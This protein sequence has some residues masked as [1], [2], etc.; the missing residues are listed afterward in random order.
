MS[1]LVALFLLASIGIAA[2]CQESKKSWHFKG[3]SGEVEIDVI[4]VPGAKGT[5]VSS[6]HI[7]SPSGGVR[8]VQEESSFIDSV[9]AQL[10][11]EGVDPNQLTMISL[12]LNESEALE[13][14]AR[15]A[16]QS[17]QWRSALRTKSIG[18]VYPLIVGFLN[19]SHAYQEWENI[20]EKR[21]FQLQ[22]VGVEEV[23]MVPFAKAGVKCPPKANCAGLLVPDDALVQINLIPIHANV[24]MIPKSSR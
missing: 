22:V 6:L 14:L 12:R 24:T 17:P 8:S 9:L 16:A 4:T 21:G 1:K 19:A 10:P 3:R 20:F 7:S 18:K 13:R 23:M 2:Y 11:K 15:Y 5:P